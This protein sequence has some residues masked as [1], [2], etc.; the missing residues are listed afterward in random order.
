M[1]LKFN[2]E[3]TKKQGTVAQMLA[4]VTAFA[5]I[6]AI[7]GCSG[8]GSSSSSSSSEA[9]ARYSMPSEISAVPTNEDATSNSVYRS[10]FMGTLR[11]LA[12]AYADEGTDYA[13]AVTAKYVEE[14]SLMQFQ[15]LEGVL[16]AIAQTRYS[17]EV[18]EGAYTAMVAMED[19]NESTGKDQKSLQ[20]WVVQSDV[21]GTALRLQA[22][23]EEKE[24]GQTMFIKAEFRITEPPTQ[25]PDGS[26]VDYGEWT[27]NV[28]FDDLGSDN[29]FAAS[30]EIGDDGVTIVKV[31]EKF[32]DMGP[33]AMESKAIMY[34]SETSGYGKVY[35]P[36]MEALFDFES[37][38]QPG[39][40][41]PHKQAAYAYDANYLSLADGDSNDVYSDPVVKDRANVIDMTHR[42]GVFNF[43]TGADLIK[44]KTF[45]FPFRYTDDTNG[46]MHSY[47]GAWQ[48][49]HQIWGPD[50]GSLAEGTEVTKE[51][52]G[53]D[54]TAVA[55]TVGPTFNG[56]LTKRT[57]MVAELNDIKN[58]P[59][60]IWLNEEYQLFWDSSNTRWTFCDGYMDWSTYPASC[61]GTEKVFSDVIGFEKLI[62]NENDTKKWVYIGGFDS[63]TSQQKTFMYLT[64][65]TLDGTNYPAGLYESTEDCTNGCTMTANDPRVGINTTNVTDLFVN[66]G[67][68]AYVAYT[69]PT[70]T[71]WVEKEL[72]NINQRTWAPEFGSNDIPF[73]LPAGRELYMNM[74]GASYVIKKNP[75][76]SAITVFFELQSVCNPSNSDTVLDGVSYFK[77]P[78]DADNSSTYTFDTTSLMLKYATIGNNDMDQGSPRNGIA[79]GDIVSNKWGVTAYN[80]SHAVVSG[81]DGYPVQFNWEYNA[82][83]GWQSVT[84]LKD[85]ND[86]YVL[87]SDPVRFNPITATDN[88][89]LEKNLVLQYDG[90]MM[91]LPDLYMDLQNNNWVMTTA[92]SAK[93]INLTAGFDVIDSV[94]GTA[95]VLKPLEISQFLAVI[96]DPSSITPPDVDQGK[97]VDLSTVPDFVEHNM[98]D[99]PTDT[100]VKYSEGVAVE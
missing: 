44:S 19:K 48:G 7:G 94:T 66:L 65:H 1:K 60:E 53:S 42:Y 56:V 97:A 92:L 95:Y 77:D 18:G 88:G 12:R 70:D 73:V 91:G 21:D 34:R 24:M 11:S 46:E 83:G 100:T 89:G 28:K 36:D 25:N 96:D 35:Y 98:G 61:V 2:N 78:W 99:M 3:K 50:G 29:F 71:D 76:T 93:I 31:H 16:D 64:A 52:F 38:W 4:V 40:A 47:Y 41:I 30:C 43:E 13:N 22:W 63:S 57:Y 59:V 27:L 26:Y 80:S 86:A 8:G 33:A 67:G 74:E 23:I 87:L 85:S 5:L 81:S 79:V 75:N 54:E 39:D 15:Q 90:W 6:V 10:T 49:R 58:V 82:N 20:K 9:V 45:G 72:I 14:H 17:E 84:Y 37:T 62:V 68:S 55:Y 32:A 69:G 51:T